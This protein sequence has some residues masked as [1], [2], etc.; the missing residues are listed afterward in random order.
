MRRYHTSVATRTIVFIPDSRPIGRSIDRSAALGPASEYHIRFPD[1]CSP[2]RLPLP[3]AFAGGPGACQLLCVVKEC[4]VPAA[5]V[6]GS[7]TNPRIEAT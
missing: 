1:R 2:A 7:A 6:D 3:H 5:A 4:Q